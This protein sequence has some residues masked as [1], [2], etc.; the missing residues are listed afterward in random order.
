MSRIRQIDKEAQPLILTSGAFLPNRHD[1]KKFYGQSSNDT[2]LAIYNFGLVARADPLGFNVR[3]GVFRSIFDCDSQAAGLLF[4][5]DQ[6]GRV[7]RWLIM[8]AP[9]LPAA[10]N[11]RLTL[12]VQRDRRDQRHSEHRAL[13]GLYARTRGEPGR[14][15]ERYQSERGPPAIRTEQ[16]DAGVRWTISIGV[17]AIVGV[18]DVAMPYFSCLMPKSRAKG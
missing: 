9:G 1:R 8:P 13:Y 2:S 10:A 17:A 11:R 5:A 16:K 4:G 12:A 6:T 18:F 15:A 3:L 7:A 14:T